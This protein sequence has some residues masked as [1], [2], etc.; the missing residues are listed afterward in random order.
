MY[1]YMHE[2]Y[3]MYTNAHIHTHTYKHI[4]VYAY[5][6]VYLHIHMR[7]LA[8]DEGLLAHIGR[9]SNF[10]QLYKVPRMHRVRGYGGGDGDHFR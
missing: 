2:Q 5:T 8:T 6:F 1:V 4:N 7:N 9:C 3:I 10:F